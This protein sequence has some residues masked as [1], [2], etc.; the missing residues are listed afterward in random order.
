MGPYYDA[1]W[2]RLN[3][4]FRAEDVL[5]YA[6]PTTDYRTATTDHTKV[7]SWINLMFGYGVWN[8][9]LTSDTLKLLDPQGN[10]IDIEVHYTRWGNTG[11]AGRMAQ[12]RPKVDLAQNTEYTV[13]LLPGIELIDGTTLKQKITYAFRTA[14]APGACKTVAPR[15]P[16]APACDLYAIPVTTPVRPA[17]R[18]CA[19]GGN[20]EL[21]W[22]LLAWPMLRLL[23]RRS[24]AR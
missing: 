14:C 3:G 1:M 17:A 15:E 7:D 20:G 21:A 8:R 13:A 22:L 4:V 6:S 19:T 5:I 24:V 18:G 9:S 23:R 11:S 12:L 10:A 16:A 2:N